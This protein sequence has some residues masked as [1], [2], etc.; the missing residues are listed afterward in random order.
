MLRSSRAE[1]I[2]ANQTAGIIA[3]AMELRRDETGTHGARRIVRHQLSD[4]L[5]YLDG[6]KLGDE[7]VHCARKQLKKARATLRLLRDAL[8][9]SIYRRENLILR[10]VARPLSEIRDSKVL[11]DTLEKLVN[12][13]GAVARAIPLDEFR[14]ALRRDRLRSR[15]ALTEASSRPIRAA[16]RQVHERCAR[17]RV[18]DAGWRVIGSGLTRIYGKGRE[19]L[20]ASRAKRSAE[21]LHE[22]RKQVKYLWHQLQILEPL[23]PAL[24][25]ELADQTHQLADYLGDDHD[26]AVLRDKLIEH[27]EVF[28]DA[29]SRS[30]LL[31]LLDRNRVELQDKAFVLGARIFEERPKEFEARFGR[32]W[33]DWQ[34]EDRLLAG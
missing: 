20:E 17:W 18:G 6:K 25:G 22:W 10:D 8:G 29:A 19:G 27:K 28:P 16:L 7:Q 21:N 1:I 34:R 26:L 30:A 14:K 4:A 5:D 3:R 2:S 24:I 12:R 31:A 9:D 33:N 11:L 23:W 32:Y 15:R 13:Y